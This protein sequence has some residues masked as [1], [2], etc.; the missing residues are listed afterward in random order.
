MTRLLE[1]DRS[2]GHAARLIRAIAN[3]KR[4]ILLCHMVQGEH[5]VGELSRLVQLS[6]SAVSQH[7]A[8]LRADNLVNV[9]R[10]SQTA[11]YSLAC[12]KVGRVIE[13]LH[14]VYCDPAAAT[15]GEVPAL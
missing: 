10:E 7:L 15:A 3:E 14:G 1:M 8:R 13:T 6:Q 9:R 5:T 4:L 11:Y 2:A 12:S